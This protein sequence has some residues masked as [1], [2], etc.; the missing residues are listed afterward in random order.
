MKFSRTIMSL[1]L[2]NKRSRG[3]FWASINVDNPKRHRQ[4]YKN[5]TIFM[6]YLRP[7]TY[8]IIIMKYFHPTFT[9]YYP[10]SVYFRTSGSDHG[11]YSFV[12]S[13]RFFGT[14]NQLHLYWKVKSDALWP[15]FTWLWVKI[16]RSA[17]FWIYNRY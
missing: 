12:S 17:C 2:L 4:G 1:T 5:L 10:N 11:Y 15:A 16:V 8:T 7:Y 3:Y 14:Y 6:K 13:R 9:L